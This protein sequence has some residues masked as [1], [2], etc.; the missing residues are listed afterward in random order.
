VARAAG[1]PDKLG[2]GKGRKEPVGCGIGLLPVI[3]DPELVFG[4]DQLVGREF[5]DG[6]RAGTRDRRSTDRGKEMPLDTGDEPGPEG[7]K[8]PA[9]LSGQSVEC[10]KGRVFAG[11][12]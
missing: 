5:P 3:V 8:S 12:G 1:N 7:D 6:D 4:P 2:P 9:L 10:E 11:F